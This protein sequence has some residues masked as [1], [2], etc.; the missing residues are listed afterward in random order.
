MTYSTHLR[1]DQWGRIKGNLEKRAT[2]G[3]PE[4]TIGVLLK[5]SFGWD[6]VVVGGAV[7]LNVYGKWS[8]VHKQTIFNTLAVDADREWVMIDSAIVRAHR[9]AVGAKKALLRGIFHQ[10]SRGV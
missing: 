2:W 9:H 6:A 8:S 7:Y 5:V 3:S 10:N 4:K 1:K